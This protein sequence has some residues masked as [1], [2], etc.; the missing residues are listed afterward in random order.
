MNNKEIKRIDF[1][2][3]IFKNNFKSILLLIIVFCIFALLVFFIGLSF[4]SNIDI[5]ILAIFASILSLGYI[6]LTYNFS[7]KIAIMSVGAKEADKN[8]DKILYG[9]VE[10]MAI[11][12][13]LPMPKVYIM[14]G[15][16]INA[17]A[18]GKNPK[19]SLVCVTNGAIKKLNE[20][21]LEAVIGHEMSHIG[22]YDIKFVTIVAVV[23]GAISIFSELFLRSL[24]YRDNNDNNRNI[25]FILIAIVFAILAPII[26]KLVQ[27]SISR[28]REYMADAGSV[29][30]TRYPKGLIGALNK[31]QND[32]ENLKVPGAIAPMFFSDTTK[33]RVIELFQTH[34]TIKKRIDALERM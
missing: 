31:I 5:F 7:D 13:G 14:K 28:K 19:N 22:N 32:H 17:F 4:Q 25:I 20:D 33:K 26:V 12:S 29:Q 8:K 27:L 6:L 2:D 23:V 21:E 1:R 16:Q 9:A 11:A 30:F 18:T 15:E 34:P 24:W 3:Q 10:K